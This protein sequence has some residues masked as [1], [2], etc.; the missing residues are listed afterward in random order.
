MGW[1][2]LSALYI[3]TLLSNLVVQSTAGVSLSRLE[4]YVHRR[5]RDNEEDAKRT[6]NFLTRNLKDLNTVAIISSRILNVFFACAL[7]SVFSV[8]HPGAFFLPALKTLLVFFAVVVFINITVI[9]QIVKKHAALLLLHAALPLRMVRLPFRPVLA[10]LRGAEAAVCRI[11][12][13]ED[14]GD[15]RITDEEILNMV[16]DV[17]IEGG[18]HAEEK[19]MIEGVLDFKDTSVNEI[20][21]PR[22]DMI[23][24]DINTPVDQAVELSLESGF[25]RIPVFENDRDHIAGVLYVKDLLK[26]WGED[27][28]SKLLCSI[29]RMPVFIPETKK[30]IELLHE[31]RSRKI[32]FA[33]AVDEYGGTA[34]VITIEDIIEEIVGEIHDEYDTETQ[35]EITKIGTD[36][37]VVEGR[38]H[39]D[40]I[41]ELFEDIEIQDT[42]EFETMGG[43]IFNHLGRIPEISETFTVNG[44]HCKILAVDERKIEKIMITIP[45]NEPTETATSG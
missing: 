8:D 10:A 22:T 20:M 18:L 1:L 39:I 11:L 30:I 38:T 5:Y 33:V 27:N 35:N 23:S 40:D 26:Y 21:T 4:L 45:K 31:F 24:I 2:Q 28:E 42:G 32:H 9:Q 25:S 29:I 13:L 37:Y 41:N 44:M 34:G 3:F 16:S 6:F 7:F 43:L 14:A 12:G 15:K 19:E 36:A 17:E